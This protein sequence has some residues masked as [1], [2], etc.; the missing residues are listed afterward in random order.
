MSPDVEPLLAP[1][2]VLNT[3]SL[4][5]SPGKILLVEDDADSRWL[6][7]LVLRKRGYDVL[8][9][10]DGASALRMAREACP[11]V[12]LVDL[13]LPDMN[14]EAVAGEIRQD[15]RLRHMRLVALTGSTLAA[16]PEACSRAGFDTQLT[17][18]ADVADLVAVLDRLLQAKGP[19]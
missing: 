18:P 15:E 4:V 13:G 5:S 16:D 3:L 2:D 17:K 8:E 10:E 6:L 1:C 14:G 11:A 19:G 12:A 9:A 7:A